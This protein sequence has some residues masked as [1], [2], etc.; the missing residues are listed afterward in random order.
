[1]MKAAPMCMS[2][3]T[4][5]VVTILAVMILVQAG[6]LVRR[7]ARG[8]SDFGVYHRTIQLVHGGVGADLYPRADAVSGWPVVLSPAGLALLYPLG[9]LDTPAASTVWAAVNL[10]LV[11]VSLAGLRALV[12]Q[13]GSSA[14]QAR[15]PALV[16]IYFVLAAGSIQVGQLTVLFT[17]CWIVALLQYMKGRRMIGNLLLALPATIKVY[18][19]LLLAVPLSL[20][21]ERRTPRR[22]TLWFAGGIVITA[23][24]IPA[25]VLGSRAVAM[26]ASFVEHVIL[27]NAQVE[28]QQRLNTPANQS[29]DTVLL[30]YLTFDPDFHPRFPA[31]PHLTLER[32]YVLRLADA[33]RAVILVIVLAVVW[34]WRRSCPAI[35]N[36]DVVGVAALWCATLYLIMPETKARYAVYTVL[37]FAPLLDRANSR[38][39]QA[40]VALCAILTTVLVPVALQSFGVGFAGPLALWIANVRLFQRRADAG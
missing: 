34:R 29:L 35:S 13:T 15:F 18:P 26:N 14:L 17:T 36:G 23:L 4:R 25:M 31:V 2:G 21:R 9:W 40:A 38:L 28:F 11:G 19:A 30:R 10:A 3:P 27:S 37:A 32:A 22:D 24:L 12:A 39:A 8:D 33:S 20:A 7:G 16:A 6:S 5:L 1:M